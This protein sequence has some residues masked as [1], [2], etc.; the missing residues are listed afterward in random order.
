MG[1]A[2]T[3][4]RLLRAWSF[5]RLET[6]GQLYTENTVGSATEVDTEGFMFFLSI[7][8]AYTEIWVTRE[9]HRKVEGRFENLPTVSA[10]FFFF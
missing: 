3:S 2:R 5:K 1:V 9:L 4:R 10:F 6:K 8:Q 7:R